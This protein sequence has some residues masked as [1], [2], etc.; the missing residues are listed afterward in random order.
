MSYP[1]VVC[2]CGFPDCVFCAWA[3]YGDDQECFDEFL[4]GNQT[5]EAYYENFGEFEP[6]ETYGSPW[7][8]SASRLSP[9]RG[10]PTR[11]V[12]MREPTPPIPGTPVSSASF[13]S[14]E[15]PASCP[16]SHQLQRSSP[17]VYR[18]GATRSQAS[19]QQLP[20]NMDA[21]RIASRSNATRQPHLEAPLPVYRS[22]IPSRPSASLR[23]SPTSWLD[24][25]QRGLP[26]PFP[27]EDNLL[28]PYHSQSIDYGDYILD[29]DDR[30]EMDTS[31]MSAR[32][33][34][35]DDSANYLSEGMH[36]I[37]TSLAGIFGSQ[38]YQHV[39]LRAQNLF[40]QSYALQSQQKT[41]SAAFKPSRRGQQNTD[42]SIDTRR[43]YSRRK[44]FV[45]SA[46]VAS[47]KEFG[48]SLPGHPSDRATVDILSCS[49]PGDLRI[50]IQS[51]KKC[52]RDL[53]LDMRFR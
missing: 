28:P 21:P 48:L 29:D 16:T 1:Q 37:E 4:L 43:R 35:D 9:T 27:L 7:R 33:E 52:C 39:L 12:T 10:S 51:V 20:N 13:L 38:Y 47:L 2:T 36:E 15:N 3:N 49:V 32:W 14:S 5:Y 23:G 31:R 26:S 42:S 8:L 46:I 11:N 44:A 50:T 6:S 22:Q 34:T 25:H 53:G 45:I 30:R 19:G 41:G 40:Q 18:T 17:E 24:Q